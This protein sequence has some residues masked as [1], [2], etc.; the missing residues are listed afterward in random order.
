MN[1]IQLPEALLG[2][3]SIESFDVKFY[4]HVGM[5]PNYRSKVSF[6]TNCIS[7]LIRGKKHVITAD[8]QF[9]YDNT[10]CLLFKTGNYLSTEISTDGKPYHSIL[11]FFNDNAF[12]YFKH[13]Y[14]HLLKGDKK[15]YSNRS[16]HFFETDRYIEGFKMAARAA[17]EKQKTFS[18]SMQMLKFEE[19]MLH[20]LEQYGR[21]V[22][23]FFDHGQLSNGVTSFK[24]IVET[25][26]LNN[27]SIDELAFLCA[28]S[29][30]TFKRTFVEVY[31]KSPGQW[32]KEKRLDHSAFLLKVKKRNP[33]EVYQEVGFSNLS[34]FI[35]SFK[36]KFGLTPK[37]Y[38]LN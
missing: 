2:S 25:N 23:D 9:C 7:L 30:S 36:K 37:Q 12:R 21:I 1:I 32:H 16:Y 6:N 18:L 27:I 4:Y 26:L 34:G 20:L 11:I 3:V 24:N 15:T 19:I 28:M 8:Q 38:Q 22:T 10:S 5:H 13:K 17:L 31:G 14:L 29:K 33:S 35:Q